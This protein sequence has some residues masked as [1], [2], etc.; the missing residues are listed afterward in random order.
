[1]SR[2]IHV[3]DELVAI[4]FIAWRKSQMSFFFVSKFPE[5]FNNGMFEGFIVF[6]ANV[7][8]ILIISKNRTTL[9]YI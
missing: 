6:I 9:M 2:K 5:V 1:M 4:P 8:E 7:F 3:V